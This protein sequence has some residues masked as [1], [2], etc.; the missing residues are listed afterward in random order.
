[1]FK[2]A[3]TCS[4]KNLIHIKLSYLSRTSYV[5]LT[6]RRKLIVRSMMIDAK[7]VLKFKKAPTVQRTMD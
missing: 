6:K 4:L 1:M 7:E 3:A 2:F 5:C